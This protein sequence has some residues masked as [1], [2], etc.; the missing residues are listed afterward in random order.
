ML[1]FTELTFFAVRVLADS[2]D[3]DSAGWAAIFLVAG[4]AFYSFMYLKYRN[5]D[6]RHHH[7]TETQASKANVQGAETFVESRKKL[8]NARMKDANDQ[9]VRGARAGAK[10]NSMTEL[11]GKAKDVIDP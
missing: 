5:T 7:E 9:E 6:K 3:D 11:A 2:S 4:F 1:T 8:K 10:K